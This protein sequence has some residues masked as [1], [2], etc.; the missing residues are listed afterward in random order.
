VQQSYEAFDFRGK[1]FVPRAETIT[2]DGFLAGQKDCSST[3]ARLAGGTLSR[4]AQSDSAVVVKLRT[5]S[6]VTA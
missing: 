2:P 6:H 5:S 3:K 1:L 4:L